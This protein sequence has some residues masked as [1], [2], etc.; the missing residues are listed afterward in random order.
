MEE[1]NRKRIR[2]KKGEEEEDGRRRNIIIESSIGR[3]ET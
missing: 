2:I 3:R 1:I